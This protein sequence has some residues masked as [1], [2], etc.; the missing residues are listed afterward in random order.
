MSRHMSE[1]P[2]PVRE[3]HLLKVLSS[4]R[5]LKMQG[6]GNEVPFFICPFDPGESVAMDKA[7]H[8]LSNNLAKQGVTALHIDLYDLAVQLLKD[9]DVWD[10]ILEVEPTRDKADVLQMLQS[11]LDPQTE[12]APAIKARIEASPHDMVLI[13][14]VGEVFPYIRSH[15]VLNNL[16]TVTKGSPLVMFFPG[17]YRQS[18]TRGS[19]LEL[20]CRLRDDQYYRAFNIYDYAI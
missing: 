10:Q 8:R 9:G 19:S 7:L 5:F 13:T 16:Q 11:L 2:V 12:L 15:N 4:D 1:E 20:F 14:G 18:A 17:D 3:A 6:L